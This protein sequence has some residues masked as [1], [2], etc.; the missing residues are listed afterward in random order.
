MFKDEAFAGLI[1]KNM[2]KQATD[3]EGNKNEIIGLYL[4]TLN[5]LLLSILR[6]ITT[7]PKG[8]KES[9]IEI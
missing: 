3:C 1:I 9:F 8:Y 7:Y 2:P 5:Y 4:Q 6:P